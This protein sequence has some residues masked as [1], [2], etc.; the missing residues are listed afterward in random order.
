MESDAT[1]IDHFANNVR[2]LCDLIESHSSFEKYDFLNGCR[3]LLSNLYFLGL[4]LPEGDYHEGIKRIPYGHDN[5]LKLYE[6]LQIYL[7]DDDTY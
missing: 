4:N 2:S 7:N 6:S 5:W 1:L 3:L